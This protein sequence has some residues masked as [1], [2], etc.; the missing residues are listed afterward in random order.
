MS[1]RVSLAIEPWWA[2]AICS[3]A[4]SLRALARRSARRRLLTKIIVERWARTSSIRRGWIAGQIDFGGVWSRWRP[5]VWVV[6]AASS[7]ARASA[8]S[9]MRSSML[10]L[11]PAST[12][13]TGAR[14]GPVA[15]DL[16]AAEEGGDLLERALG[17]GQA[18]AL[19][20]RELGISGGVEALEREG[21]VGAA[22]GG[23]EA[24]DLVDDD[25]L[26]AAQELARVGGEH[27]V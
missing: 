22:L 23:D 18:D 27:Q 10:G 12:I 7:A 16:E 24:V 2:M 3:P 8:G 5:R 14:P 13:V 19:Q 21:E 26:D 1:A 11:L 9:S 25:G 15:G 6:S 17:G 20:R 4:S